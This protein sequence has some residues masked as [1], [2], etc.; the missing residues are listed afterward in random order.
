MSDIDMTEFEETTKRVLAK[1]REDSV[2]PWRRLTF[3]L[4]VG[5]LVL[6]G[7]SIAEFVLWQVAR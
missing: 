5:Y 2:R 4:L 1:H 6:L 7:L 3:W